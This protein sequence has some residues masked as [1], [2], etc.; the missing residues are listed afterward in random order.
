MNY[1]KLRQEIYS[2]FILMMVSITIILT[3]CG[4]IKSGIDNENWVYIIGGAFFF[5]F[6]GYGFFVFL[7]R[8]RKVVLARKVGDIILYEKFRTLKEIAEKVNASQTKV[9]GA[10]AFLIDNEYI[11][12]IKLERDRVV[13]FSEERK[14]EVEEQAMEIAKILNKT[15]S[16]KYTNGAKCV[17]CGASVVFNGES[18]ICPYCG[19]L[20]KPNNDK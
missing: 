17:N 8:I 15:N 16:K 14:R 2:F 7:A 6:T 13:V 10:I 19:S 20:L 3:S 9:A 5:C 12:G 11:E 4:Y 1:K 18:A